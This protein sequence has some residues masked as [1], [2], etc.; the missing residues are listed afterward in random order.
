MFLRFFCIHSNQHGTE[1]T[2]QK[3]KSIHKCHGND[4]RIEPIIDI[5]IYFWLDEWSFG[6]VDACIFN[7]LVH[8]IKFYVTDNLFKLDTRYSK[9]KSY[10]IS[11]ICYNYKHLL[12][13]VSCC[14]NI[15]IN[16][17]GTTPFFQFRLSAR[18]VKS[19]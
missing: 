14:E 10:L 12:R 9:L 3:R 8:A 19:N 13:K 18:F 16:F 11:N 17:R 5:C 7:L 4:F 1:F 15:K 2:I 6:C